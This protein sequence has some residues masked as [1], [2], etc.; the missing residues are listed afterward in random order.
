M[1]SWDAWVERALRESECKRDLNRSLSSGTN[2]SDNLSFMSAPSTCINQANC[3][4]FHR[5]AVLT[6]ISFLVGKLCLRTTSGQ[7]P[8]HNP[9]LHLYEVIYLTLVKYIKVAQ[10]F[11]K[12]VCLITSTNVGDASTIRATSASFDKSPRREIREREDKAALSS[13][14]VP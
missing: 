13:D 8:L 6:L 10:T 14:C 3:Q 11:H 7:F 12:G 5:E 2:G 9:F 1:E 4:K